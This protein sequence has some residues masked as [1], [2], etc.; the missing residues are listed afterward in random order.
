MDKYNWALVDESETII[1]P[2]DTVTSFRGEIET[3]ISGRPPHK[4]S[5]SGFVNTTGGEYYA[6]V[7]GLKWVRVW[8]QEHAT[9]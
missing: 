3:V 9:S 5:S 8:E 7:Y 2:G 6:H 4:P 1:M